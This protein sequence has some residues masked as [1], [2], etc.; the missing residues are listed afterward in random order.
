MSLPTEHRPDQTTHIGSLPRPHAVLDL[1]KAKL[2]GQ[3]LRT[4]R[5]STPR[6]RRPVVDSV[7]KQVECGID[8]V[9]DGELSKAGF[10]TYIRRAARGVRGAA[11]RKVHPL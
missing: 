4:K 10:F 7:K 3:P 11:E 5:R 9:T 6:S 8:I 1:L 2:T